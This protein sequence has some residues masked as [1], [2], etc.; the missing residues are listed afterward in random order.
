MAEGPPARR[1][2]PRAASGLWSMPGQATASGGSPLLNRQA[3]AQEL[4]R[5][6]HKRVYRVMKQAG[7]LLAPPPVAAGS[8]TT[9]RSSPG[10]P[11]RAASGESPYG[12]S[13]CSPSNGASG[14]SKRQSR[15]SG[16]PTTQLLHSARD[17]RVRLRDRPSALFHPGPQPRAKTFK[18]DYVRLNPRPDAAAVMAQLNAWFEDYN[19]MHPHPRPRD[20]LT[21]PVHQGAPTRRLSGLTGTTP[22]SMAGARCSAYDDASEAETLWSS[23]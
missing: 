9:A 12:T 22:P 16:W 1:A 10:R 15:S 20:T 11:A 8:P 17:G 19:E 4:A 3:E 14:L 6:N 7:L 18:R 13:C 2:G 23:S 5:A 21:P